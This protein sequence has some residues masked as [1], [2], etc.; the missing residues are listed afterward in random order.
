MLASAV[1]FEMSPDWGW[2][3]N[4]AVVVYPEDSLEL[5]CSSQARYSLYSV[6]NHQ[7]S[8][9]DGHYTTFCRH[10]N[11]ESSP[12]WFCDDE[13][14]QYLD[15]ERFHSNSNAYLLFY[16]LQT[17]TVSTYLWWRKLYL[18]QWICMSLHHHRSGNHFYFFG[19]SV[20]YFVNEKSPRE[21]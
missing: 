9:D 3:K 17:N 8:L 18:T 12:W 15:K 20:I 10:S 2:I 13:K 7:G 21:N 1:R 19:V 4:Q 6:I 5:K 16:A 11:R 14:I